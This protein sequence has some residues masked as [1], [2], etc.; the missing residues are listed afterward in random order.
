[1]PICFLINLIL[2]LEKASLVFE[3]LSSGR[4]LT[5][6]VI[7]N[8]IVSRLINIKNNAQTKYNCLTLNQQNSQD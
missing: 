8:H 1:M 7:W 2:A 5:S 4:M 3:Q 6:N